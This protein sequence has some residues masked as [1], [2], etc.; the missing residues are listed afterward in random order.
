MFHKLKVAVLQ[1]NP[2]GTT[3]E[4]MEKGILFCKKAKETGAD[5]PE[6]L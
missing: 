3:E 2:V 6:V 1:M 4:N 5:D